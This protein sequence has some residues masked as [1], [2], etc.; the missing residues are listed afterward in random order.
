[1]AATKIAAD[2][3]WATAR[4]S[5]RVRSA[6]EPRK[7][8][9]SNHLRCALALHLVDTSHANRNRRRFGVSKQ[10]LSRALQGLF[11]FG[12]R[13]HQRHRIDGRRVKSTSLVELPRLFR[14]RVD[15]DRTNPGNARSL[16]RSEDRIAHHGPTNP[17]A[18]KT[19]INGEPT[20]HHGGNRVWHIAP[21]AT[22]RPGSCY[23]ANGK[24]V[25]GNN[26]IP[27]LGANHVRPGA[28]TDFVS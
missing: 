20:N 22:R 8:C 9:S 7:P 27:G 3:R 6:S 11:C 28:T 16:D 1:M 10:S 24:A 12:N 14:G 21:H 13:N 17:A 5:S 2:Y 18:L 25:I 15:E 19:V 23:R 4:G 26:S